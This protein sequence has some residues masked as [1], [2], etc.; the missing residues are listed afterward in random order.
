MKCTHCGAD[1]DKSKAYCSSCGAQL[2]PRDN[3]S[4]KTLRLPDLSQ[5]DAVSMPVRRTSAPS[6]KERSNGGKLA[7]AVICAVIAIAAAAVCLAVILSQGH[8]PPLRDIPTDE[9]KGQEY[10]DYQRPEEEPKIDLPANEPDKED[11]PEAPEEPERAPEIIADDV[12][13][14]PEPENAPEEAP[15][16]EGAPEGDTN[17]S[18]SESGE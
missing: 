6:D 1:T 7:A 14:E 5:A 11:K 4:D 2:N 16:E 3:S 18:V 8:T 10:N 9:G 12:T 17:T 15:K 13:P